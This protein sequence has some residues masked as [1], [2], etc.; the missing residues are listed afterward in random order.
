VSLLLRHNVTVGLGIEEK[1]EAPGVRFDVG[2]A[3]LDGN[4]KISREQ[5]IALASTNLEKLF[6]IDAGG[7][8]VAYRGG[9]VFDQKSK[10]VAVM[11]ANRGE[12]VL[13]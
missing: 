4:G 10:V 6:G 8:F 2:W 11:S 12:V 7:D 5:A 1:S 3:A 9:D 13:V